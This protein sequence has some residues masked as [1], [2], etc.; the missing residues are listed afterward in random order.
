MGV[1]VKIYFRGRD[2]SLDA[3]ILDTTPDAINTAWND[4]VYSEQE[5]FNLT[6]QT[7]TRLAI[8]VKNVDMLVTVKWNG[9]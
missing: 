4:A 2:N 6:D 8:T 7:G 9:I 3:Y 1:R 5:V